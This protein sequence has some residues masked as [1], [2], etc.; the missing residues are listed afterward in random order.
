MSEIT[1]NTQMLGLKDLKLHVEDTGGDGRPV[2]LI[3]GWPLSA[4]SWKQQVPTLVEAG[5]RVITY[6]RRGFGRSDKPIAGYGYGTLAEDLSGL[7]EALD[8]RDVTLVGFSMGGGEVIQYIGD[9]G[10]DRIRSIVLA[11]AVTPMMMK[12]PNNPEGPLEPTQAAK[13]TFDLTAD[14]DKFYENFTRQFFSPNADGHVLV[15]ET[16]RLEALGQCKQASQAAALEAMQSF[17]ITDF[18][19]DLGKV[20]VPTLII[21]GTAD[22]IVPFDGSGART[23]RAVPHSQLYLVEGGPHGIN[24]SHADAFNRALIDFLN[25][26]SAAPGLAEDQ[27][28]L[29][30]PLEARDYEAIRD[31][32]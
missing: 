9:H 31:G 10:E 5:F 20:S 8:L 21:H 25:D 14:A 7:L 1:V 2:V 4:S 3:H 23:H 27:S 24:V 29:T 32:E 22:G 6:D 19:K 26:A 11:S 16:E 30:A 12:L 15:S 28:V 17:G 13:M 18:R